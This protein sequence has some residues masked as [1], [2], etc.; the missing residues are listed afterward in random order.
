[1]SHWS[2]DRLPEDLHEVVQRLRDERPEATGLDLDRIKLRAMAQAR[3]SRPKGFVLRSRVLAVVLSVGLM[4]GG[5]GGVI[6]AAGG[7]GKGKGQPSG[8]SQYCPPSSPGAGKPKNP[9]PGNKCGQPPGPGQNSSKG[10][11]KK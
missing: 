9:P 7:Q 11:P 10:K 5:T 2:E 6:A 8:N 1:M 4:A 3:S